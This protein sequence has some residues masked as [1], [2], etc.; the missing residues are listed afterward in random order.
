MGYKAKKNKWSLLAMTLVAAVMVLAA[1]GN[2]EGGP[3][4]QG[5]DFTDPFQAVTDALENNNLQLQVQNDNP[6][7]EGGHLRFALGTTAE[8]TGLF[9]TVF[10]R[11]TTESDLRTFTHENLLMV[12]HDFA[13]SNAN[14]LASATYD[15]EAQTVTIT[16]NYPSL[17]ADGVPVTLDDL[18]FAYEVI[19][20][21]DYTGPRRDANMLNVVGTQAFHDGTADHIS[22]LVLSED[23]MELTI[24]F[25]EM[26]PFTYLFAF[27][28]EMVPRHHW[29]GIAVADME[30]HPR[31]RHEVLGNGPFRI[32]ETV[33]GESFLFER[34]PYFW[35]GPANLDTVEFVVVE[36]ML[37]PEAMR[38][39]MFDVINFPQSQFTAANRE[40][41]NVQ[42]LSN[43]WAGNA[44]WWLIFRMGDWN[45]ATGRVEPWAEPRH[46]E[47]VR[48]A[49]ALSID[50]LG[51]GAHLFNGLVV[52]GGSV[53]WP[54][55]RVDWVD[56]SIPTFNTF[57]LELANQML[58]DAGYDERDSDGF[59]INPATGERVVV[60]YAAQTGSQANVDN[61][62]LELETWNY[63]LGINVVLF[64]DELVQQNV[65]WD[66]L[67]IPTSN[68]IDMF[69]AGT[70]FGANPTPTWSFSPY[71]SNNHARFMN[72][73]IEAAFNRFASDEMWNEDFLLETVNE[74]QHAISDARV[75]FPTT[76]ALGLT[77]VNNRVINFSM[78]HNGGDNTLPGR[79]AQGW[80][81]WLWG[82]SADER[83]IS[84]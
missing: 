40:M 24:H 29:E 31:A 73:E 18:V 39:G 11:F 10:T 13:P 7:I 60:V 17:W 44:T 30:A 47:T 2:N 19:N 28:T 16:K 77:A 20:H 6:M 37:A 82:L 14:T 46:S 52:P 76:T 61:R 42:F 54:N 1:C 23:K 43:P 68:E 21:P 84:N 4:N 67:D 79:Q 50:H 36:P 69:T 22:G 27:W 5:A 70:A 71:S 38:A 49:L 15:R 45:E 12:G 26:T 80:N 3:G 58:D 64:N 59:R 41:D 9:E 57:N 51:A 75:W 66:A 33:P 78:E 65:F 34:N 48:T 32:A 72:D 56:R 25:Y 35:R 63:D 8:L 83:Y 62:H 81:T 74:I 55:N 53:L